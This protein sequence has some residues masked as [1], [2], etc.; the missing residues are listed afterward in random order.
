MI[1]KDEDDITY[2]GSDKIIPRASLQIHLS[3]VKHKY[4]R[5]PYSVFSLLSDFGGFNEA[6][7]ILP[8]LVLRLYRQKMFESAIASDT[9]VR[10]S[11]SKSP[12][13][14]KHKREAQSRG[15]IS[16]A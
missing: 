12:Q 4:F 7:V 9:Q 5:Q 15:V 11:K 6:V 16:S 10:G 8:A 14:N 2:P 3:D 13:I 1:I